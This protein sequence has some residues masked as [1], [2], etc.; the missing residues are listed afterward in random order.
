ME[1]CAVM[2]GESN[3]AKAHVRTTRGRSAPG[4][5]R[6]TRQRRTVLH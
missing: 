6:R 3:G 4:H 5:H 2:W 1:M